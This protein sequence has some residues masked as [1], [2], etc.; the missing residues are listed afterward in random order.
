MSAFPFTRAALRRPRANIYF[1]AGLLRV[2]TLQCRALDRIHGGAKHRHAVSHFRWGDRVRGARFENR[3]FESRRR[4]LAA[5]GGARS[6]PLAAYREFPLHR[7]LAGAPRQLS[8]PYN[9][10][11]SPNRLHKGVDF[12][13]DHGEPVRAVAD[14]VVVFA[15]VDRPG[16]GAAWR[17][18]PNRARRVSKRR[19]GRGG[20]FVLIDHGKGFTS[21]YF[22]LASYSVKQGDRVRGGEAI[23]KVGRSG[24]KYS[25]AHL[26]FEMRRHGRHFNPTSW[27]QPM[28]GPPERRAPRRSPRKRGKKRRKDDQKQRRYLPPLHIA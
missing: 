6:R 27:M 21:G 11:R 24:I 18:A 10:R 22:H 14:G 16:R 9:A 4:L 28:L 5:H 8:S 20:L 2:Q 12:F 25:A 7:P 26:H 15:G 19:M 23:G 1:T 13:S 17:L 3:V